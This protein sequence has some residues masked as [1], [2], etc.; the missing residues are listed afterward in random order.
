MR[1]LVAIAGS[2][3]A[4]VLASVNFAPWNVPAAMLVAVGVWFWLL[5][6]AA[7]ARARTVLAMGFAFGWGFMGPL[8]WWMNAVD[9]AAW[10]ALV[11]AQ[12]VF[13]AVIA[14]ALRAAQRLP[15]WPL[16][17]AV[18]WT[19]GESLRGAVPFS[20]FPWGRL[21][22]TTIDTPLDSWVRL[23]GMPATS[24]LLALCAGLVAAAVERRRAWLPTAAIVG[25][26]V[27][28]SLVLP[29]GIAGSGEQYRV[30]VVQGGTPGPFLQW[31]RGEIFQLHLDATERLDEPV[32]MVLWPENA[33][34][35]DPFTRTWAADALNAAVEE[36]GAPILVGGLLDGP[37]DMTAYNAGFV[38]DENGAGDV[39]VKRQLVPYGEYVP[40]RQQLGDLVPRFDRD[41][42]RDMVPGEEPGA[43][44][45]AG[46]VIG[47]TICW[48][49]AYD[50]VIREAV[51][52]GA[53]FLV[54]QTSNASFEGT[55]Q[56]RQQW[57]ISR[58]RA[59][60]TGRYVVVPSTNGISGV[61]A[62]DGSV[63]AEG[64]LLEPATIVETITGATGRT[65]AHTMSAPLE[66]LICALASLGVV[67]GWR[68]GRR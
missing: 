33:T 58:L 64:P 44:R 65:P 32:D 68:R 55:S 67:A 45:I 59:V 4:G 48:D 51:E 43:L 11:M 21:V 36:V 27:G 25:A 14:W 46:A 57:N 39:Y 26:V 37:T 53:E 13:Y 9:P 34:D 29:T 56:L 28:V 66:L 50:G 61:V 5:R 6:Q 15:W 35:I 16:W 20:G 22:H 31:P 49:I 7:A 23:I 17:A 60:E 8:I 2:A 40:F 30:G 63:V 62:P 42:P 47:D 38:W 10:V 12:A 24:A 52:A 18:V 41:I 3:V 1:A 54:V 19:A